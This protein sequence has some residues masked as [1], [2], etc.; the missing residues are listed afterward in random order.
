MD[1]GACT[2][3][4]SACAPA[5]RW[6]LAPPWRHALLSDDQACSWTTVR[7]H[8]V[9]V[10]SNANGSHNMH[11][12]SRLQRIRTRSG[13]PRVAAYLMVAVAIQQ[14]CLRCR[15]WPGEARM[16]R[17]RIE[18]ECSRARRTQPVSPVAAT[19]VLA[20]GHLR[21][22]A[23]CFSAAAT[24]YWSLH[25]GQRPFSTWMQR[26][27]VRGRC[28]LSVVGASCQWSV[29]VVTCQLLVP[30]AT[31]SQLNRWR[32]GF[33]EATGRRHP[34]LNLKLRRHCPQR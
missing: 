20:P 5:P 29:P 32:A 14:P 23:I 28:Q 19:S 31:L 13:S 11:S 24:R 3:N 21:A 16:M 30:F 6:L 12:S 1:A 7:R 10:S 9:R 33:D 4:P 26:F 25:Q 27:G 2:C 8:A 15:H 34:V 18:L 22:P 17:G